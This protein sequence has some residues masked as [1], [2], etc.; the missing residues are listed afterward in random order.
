M[1]WVVFVD[2]FPVEFNLLVGT[3]KAGLTGPADGNLLDCQ[4]RVV[5][6][7]APHFAGRTAMPFSQSSNYALMAMTATGLFNTTPAGPPS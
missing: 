7:R 6:I 4:H 2:K 3:K 1:R 5:S